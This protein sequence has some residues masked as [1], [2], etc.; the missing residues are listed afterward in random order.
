MFPPVQELGICDYPQRV[1]CKTSFNAPPTLVSTQA[2]PIAVDN[3]IN[4]V[5]SDRVA[6]AGPSTAPT[7]AQNVKTV[8]SN[9][10][11]NRKSKYL[12]G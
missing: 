3:K 9:S 2:T 11:Y 12:N 1:D 4:T 8:W 5:P 6:T 7:L 10:V